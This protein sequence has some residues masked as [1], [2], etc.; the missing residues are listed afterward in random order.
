MNTSKTFAVS[1]LMTGL[2]VLAL[3]FAV[4]QAVSRPSDGQL[5]AGAP[6]PEFRVT[7]MAGQPVR[8]SDFAG[9]GVLLNFWGTWCAPCVNE[10]PRLQA[11]SEAGMDGVEII[12]VNV[13]DSK[14]TIA[15]FMN[16][17]ALS[18]PV[19][20]DPSGEAV[21]SYRVTGLPATFAIDGK[22]TVRRIVPG[23]LASVEQIRALMRS[24]QPDRNSGSSK[25]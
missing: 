20:T 18:F 23:E 8:L 10:M 12:A 2:I 21:K 4:Y 1:G 16:A 9:K 6:A 25:E 5:R 24:V 14:G 11:A 7:D 15:E 19:M 13:G 3:A 22:G 17:H